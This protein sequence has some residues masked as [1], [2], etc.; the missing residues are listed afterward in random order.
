MMKRWIACGISGLVSVQAMGSGLA[1]DYGVDFVTIGDPGNRSPEGDELHY[2][3]GPPQGSVEYE[4]RIS[5]YEL[6]IREHL[7]FANA[8]APIYFQNNPDI[9]IAA[10]EFSGGYLLIDRNQIGPRGTNLDRATDIGWEYLARYVNWLHHG[11]VNEEWAFESGV[12]D[13]S[14]FVERDDEEW[15]P[16]EARS[17]GSRYWIPTRSE[18]EKAAYWD[19][20]KEG[21]GV[22]GYWLYPNSTDQA[23]LPNRLASEGGQRNSGDDASI[24]PL[25]VGSYPEQESPWGLLDMAGGESEWDA[26]FIPLPRGFHSRGRKGSDWRNTF[27]NVPFNQYDIDLDRR[28][29]GLAVPAGSVLGARIATSVY[30]PADLNFDGEINYFDISIFISSLLAGNSRADF[31]LDGQ[32]DIDDIN[33]F[34]GLLGLE[35]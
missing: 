31:R 7:E 21:D 29:N 17:E 35:R 15:A 30:M 27:Y 34:I 4:Y 22:G 9:F 24:F 32:F 16:Q 12:F 2:P 11:K 5:K 6:T 33:V 1:P 13:L 18:W 10:F 26:K 8:Y 19:P 25:S 23:L 3:F 14:T 20:N 28:G